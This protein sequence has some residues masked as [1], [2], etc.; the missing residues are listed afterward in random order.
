MVIDQR[1]EEKTKHKEGQLISCGTGP[2]E[3][4]LLM[5]M[6]A[7][8]RLFGTGTLEGSMLQRAEVDTRRVNFEGGRERERR[9]GVAARGRLN[10][11][12]RRQTRTVRI[13]S[14]DINET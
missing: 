7:E 4:S 13:V 6:L 9:I 10:G 11:R 14:V 1:I 12:L 2:N 8:Q 3:T 5:F